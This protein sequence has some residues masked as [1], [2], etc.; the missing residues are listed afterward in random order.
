MTDE[1]IIQL[2]TEQN[3]KLMQII[4][5]FASKGINVVVNSYNGSTAEANANG[6]KATNATNA[7]GGK[8]EN[9]QTHN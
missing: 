1:K 2:L 9:I 5:A 8:A 3:A 6:A 7:N 4:E